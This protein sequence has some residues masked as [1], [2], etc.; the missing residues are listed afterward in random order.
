[1]AEENHILKKIEEIVEEVKKNNL[2]QAIKLLMD[3]N[4]DYGKREDKN[5]LTLLMKRCN[6]LRQAKD[7]GTIRFQDASIEENQIAEAILSHK[8]ELLNI[9]KNTKEIPKSGEKASIQ[10]LEEYYIGLSYEDLLNRSILLENRLQNEL[11]KA[12]KTNI[13]NQLNC[14]NKVIQEHKQPEKDALSQKIAELNEPSQP[15]EIVVQ[16]NKITKKYR[17]TAFKLRLDE[18]QLRQS[19]IT[20]VVGENSTGKSTLLRI[21][22]GDL[23]IG[24]GKLTYPLFHNGGFAL[25]YWGKVK[26]RIAYIPQELP[27]WQGILKDNL[28]YEAAIHGIKGLDNEE[29]VNEIILRL[30]LSDHISKSWKQ[31][32]GGYKLRF[33]LA[34]ALVW[35][36]QL[37]IIDE[38]L[39][40]LDVNTQL[41][42][43]DDLQ[44]LAKIKKNPLCIILSSQHL[45]ETEA[46]ADQWLFVKD[47]LVEVIQDFNENT[48]YN[49]FELNCNLN[50][51][52]LSSL[53]KDIVINKI[54]KN[55]LAYLIETPKTTT[56]KQLLNTLLANKNTKIDYF[57]DISNSIKTKFYNEEKAN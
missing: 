29:D 43:I 28:H 24:E 21:I 37:L 47:G 56:E 9:A 3:A 46:I 41:I 13:L 17:S 49:L 25:N 31:L 5:N 51:N 26:Q 18:L 45:H 55:K 34:K 1:M 2:P 50:E 23:A 6:S 40:H 19:E 36:P 12:E 22:A 4:K 32:S 53:L 30:G 14:I 42:V 52:E 15:N 8:D 44:R 7:K 16:A 48:K 10:S 54:S 33:S 35:K 39:A 11:E 38:P 57:R 27:K 20:V